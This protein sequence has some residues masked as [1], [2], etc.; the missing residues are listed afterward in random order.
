M[1]NPTQCQTAAGLPPLAVTAL[2]K[3][4]KIAAVKIV[5]E[6]QGIQLTE[7]K[8]VVEDYIRS[9]PVIQAEL[10]NVRLNRSGFGWIILLIG[11]GILLWYFVAR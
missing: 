10:K 7:A 2:M 5:R 1:D 6:E 8:E 4:Q 9:D 11:L 3:G